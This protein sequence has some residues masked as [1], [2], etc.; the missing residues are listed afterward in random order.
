MIGE[1]NW[2]S[3]FSLHE[4]LLCLVYK[5]YCAIEN[6]RLYWFYILSS[7]WITWGKVL[8]IL[9]I[10]SFRYF[11]LFKLAFMI[12]KLWIFNQKNNIELTSVFVKH[13]IL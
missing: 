7:Y 11:K 12:W 9:D 4:N 5:I 13:L 2:N 3:F 1:G 10:F 6:N 8:D